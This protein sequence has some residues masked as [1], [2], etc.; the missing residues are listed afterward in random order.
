M[1]SIFGVCGRFASYSILTRSVGEPL[2]GFLLLNSGANRLPSLASAT[3]L[4]Y[5]ILTVF[6]APPG[7]IGIKYFLQGVDPAFHFLNESQ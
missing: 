4:Q 2:K 5:A 6:L 1:G 7:V 3:G